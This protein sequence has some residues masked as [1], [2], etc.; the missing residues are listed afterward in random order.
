MSFCTNQVLAL[1]SGIYT[2]LGSP[3]A[4]SI[5]LISGWITQSGNIGALNGRLNTCFSLSGAG[6]CFSEDFGESEAYIYGLVYQME[7]YRQ[8]AANSLAGA[9]VMWTTLKEADSTVVRESPV[10]VSQAYREL[11]EA[12]QK[13][14]HIAVANW[15]LG[16]SLV[17]SVDG[18][19]LYSWPSP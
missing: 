14:L 13:T 3:T 10:K 4:Q 16:V 8:Q 15:K 18:S 11:Q 12:T 17:S 9:G 2:N 19:S 5:G 7:Y 1:S 6:P